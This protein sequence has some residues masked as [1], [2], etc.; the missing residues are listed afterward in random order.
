MSFDTIKPA[1]GYEK[2]LPIEYQDLINHGQYGR[3]TFAEFT[4]VY[5]MQIDFAE[6]IEAE[7]NKIIE[8]VTAQPA[9]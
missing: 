8:S 3:W 2:I 6:K 5:E 4:D 9:A 1:P 7:F